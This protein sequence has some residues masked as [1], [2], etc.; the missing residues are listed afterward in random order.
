MTRTDSKPFLASPAA[1]VL[2]AFLVL[3]LFLALLT[4]RDPSG[5]VLLDSHDYVNL[6][7]GLVQ[8][9]SFQDPSGGEAD[10]V[11][12]PGYPLLL[13]GIDW[14]AGGA[15]TAV[16]LVQLILGAGAALLLLGAGRRLGRPGLGIASAWLLALSPNTALWS[17][18]VM[19]ETL[20]AALL[21]LALFLWVRGLQ[22]LQQHNFAWAGLA[23]GGAAMVRPIGLVLIPIWAVVTYWAMRRSASR[24]DALA[25]ESVLLVVAGVVVIA[26]M[27]RNQAVHGS[28]TFTSVSA[29][30]MV[31]FDLA[32]VVARGEGITRSQAAERLQGGAVLQ[33]TLAV[34]SAYPVAFVRAQLLGIGRTAAGTDI[35]T[36]GNVLNWDRWTGLGLLT[37]LL[38]QTPAGDFS[39]APQ[40]S[41]EAIIRGGLLVYSLVFTLILAG[42]GLLGIILGWR[43]G[44]TLRGLILMCAFTAATLVLAPLAAGQ[45]RFRVPAEPFLAILAGCGL[46]LTLGRRRSG[47]SPGEEMKAGPGDVL[48]SREQFDE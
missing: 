19:S 14:V 21:T 43:A 45:A 31:G 44:G 35:G 47:A 13:A 10:L 4:V 22:D 37:G 40:S 12:P 29:R 32:D 17:L 1:W 24:G 39:Q 2:L 20:F 9:G 41:T 8:T 48:V 25:M 28:W 11:R 16:S 6:A 46:V 7:T 26:W 33:Q 36:W 27:V 42:L 5:G 38:G 3:R 18:T 30:T 15:T 34:A 23:L